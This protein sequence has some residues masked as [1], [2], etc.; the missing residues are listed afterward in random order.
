MVGY[1]LAM[2]FAKAGFSLD[3]QM[4]EGGSPLTK[5]HD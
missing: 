1:W 3:E 5:E 4:G 2:L